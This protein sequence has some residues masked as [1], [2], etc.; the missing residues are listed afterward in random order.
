MKI[1]KALDAHNIETRLFSAGNLGLHPFWYMQYGKFHDS[2]AD[3]VHEC[4]FFLPNNE[5][6]EEKDINFI[7]DVVN[8]V[9]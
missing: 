2:V 9:G 1:I 6:L 7:C 8:K 4:G 3:R 5:S